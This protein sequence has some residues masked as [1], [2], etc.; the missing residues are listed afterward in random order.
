MYYC[1]DK[2]ELITQLMS[3]SHGRFIQ[4]LKFKAQE[5]QTKLSIV[6]EYYTSK[7]CGNCGKLHPNLGGCRTYV[8]QNCKKIYD[9]DVNAAR[10]I[11]IKAMN[12]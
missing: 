12:N 4:R 5:Y 7:T 3:L 11:F 10:N 1:N 2:S 6:D 8:C 9:R